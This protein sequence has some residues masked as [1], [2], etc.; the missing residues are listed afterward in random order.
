M[1]SDI[2]K[3]I[4]AVFALIVSL[5]SLYM[6]WQTKRKMEGEAFEDRRALLLN[7]YRKNRDA[8]NALSFK[9]GGAGTTIKLMPGPLTYQR[10]YL[11]EHLQKIKTIQPF[12]LCTEQDITALRDTPSG[13]KRL[14]EL[15]THEQ[16]VE[17][18]VGN[19]ISMQLLAE[20]DKLIESVKSNGS[21]DKTQ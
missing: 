1:D 3:S 16:G 17:A 12:R 8:W 4:T 7:M 6:S 2:L 14:R 11:M 5:V 10:I 21:P 13:R 15:L 19:E 9:A 20:A 18:I